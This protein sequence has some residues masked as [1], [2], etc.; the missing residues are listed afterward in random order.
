MPFTV[1]AAD[2]VAGWRIWVEMPSGR[3]LVRTFN[4]R[5]DFTA[6]IELLN[7]VVSEAG[8]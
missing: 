5:N 7:Q 4:D 3:L 8:N 2:D 6:A 1:L